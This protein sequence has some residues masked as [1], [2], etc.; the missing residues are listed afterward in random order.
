MVP[1][2]ITLKIANAYHD[3]LVAPAKHS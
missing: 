3:V 2:S 1:G